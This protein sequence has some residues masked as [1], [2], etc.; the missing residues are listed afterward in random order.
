MLDSNFKFGQRFYPARKNT[1]RLL[2]RTQPLQTMVVGP[3]NDEDIQQV[4]SEVL[5]GGNH[6]QR[7]PPS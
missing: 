6:C 1:L 4:M 2:E 3:K 5:Q 7:F